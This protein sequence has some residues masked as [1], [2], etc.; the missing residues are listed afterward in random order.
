MTLPAM[1]EIVTRPLGPNDFRAFVMV[2]RL[3]LEETPFAFASSLDDDFTNDLSV[4]ESALSKGPDALTFGAF[5][6]G[7]LAGVLHVGR[8]LKNKRK[9]VA[10]LGGM[11]VRPE[12]RRR[13]VARRLLDVAIDHSRSLGVSTIQV[14]VTEFATDARRLYESAGFRRWGTEPDA[15]RYDDRSV[16]EHHLVLRVTL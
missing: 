5:L 14:S 15:L 7:E 13:G 2:R 10:T 11:Y 6:S 8:Q 3:G 12:F 4:V 1:L 16:D 9:H